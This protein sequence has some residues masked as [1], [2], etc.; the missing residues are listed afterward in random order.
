MKIQEI[1][2][3][4]VLTIGP[5]AG[6]RDVAKILVDHRISGLP[7]C[8]TQRRVLGVISEG[9]ILFKEYDPTTSSRIGPLAWLV[10]GASENA[11]PRPKHVPL[12]RR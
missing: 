5:E 1:M 11:S 7:V 12:A 3:R 10:D 8:D 6:I 9:D 2:T 4:D